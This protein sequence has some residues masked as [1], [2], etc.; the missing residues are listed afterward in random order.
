MSIITEL[1]EELPP[2]TLEQRTKEIQGFN[3]STREF[4]V[5]SFDLT[6]QL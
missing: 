1:D 5:I 2:K 4:C 3:Y 6:L